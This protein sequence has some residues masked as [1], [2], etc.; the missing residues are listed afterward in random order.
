MICSGEA[1]PQGA[2]GPV[3]RRALD[4]ELHNLYG[5]TEAAV[6]VT[7]WACDPSSDLPVVPIGRPIANTQVHILDDAHA[8]P[9][10]S[11]RAGRAA[12][13]AAS[14]SARGYLNRP[15]LTA[16]RFIADPFAG[17]P[18]ARLYKTGDLARWLPDGNIEFLG[19]ADFQVK[20]RGFRIELGEIEAALEAI[21]GVRQAIVVARERLGWRPRARRLRLVFERR[22]ADDEDLRA[23]LLA[24]LPAYMVPTT[25][26]TIERFPLSPNGKVDRKALPAPTRV[27]PE[28]GT[29]YAAPR[30]KV[31]RLVADKWQHILD[32]EA[33]GIHD[34]FFEL[35]GTSLQAA[36]F[37]NEMQAEL[38][39]S[40]FVVTLF[41]AP[42]VA[43]YAAFLQEQYS[44]AVARLVG[45]DR[46]GGRPSIGHCAYFGGRCRA[47]AVL[48]PHRGRDRPR[49]RRQESAGYLHPEPA[50]L[51]DHPPAHHAGRP[52]RPVRR[53][54]AA[55]AWLPH[56]PGSGR[57]VHGQVQPLAGRRDSDRHGDR[58]A[59]RRRRE[60]V[61][62]RCKG[63]GP[64]HEAV[65][66]PT[67]G[68]GCAADPGGQVALLRAGPVRASP[69]RGVLRRRPVHP[70]RSATRSR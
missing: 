10:R 30:S 68:G 29:P 20:I 13:S 57:G 60:G 64:H 27:R 55:A 56:A 8:S 70:P 45:V 17:R 25:F 66:S 38:E 7:A 1:L 61:H 40:I 43:E 47:I 62:A 18:D 19:R 50:A 59:R 44:T 51:R 11:G 28:L 41:A 53:E 5:P 26:V 58:R 35:G 12:T 48:S 4:A 32:V 63:R 65:L 9:C 33:V 67:P 22:R 39:E 21:A 2:P 15:E 31:E 49:R 34:R 52:P 36:R 23:T 6:D 37:V 46:C 3:L 54:R 69:G 24:R 16:E 42:S 14:R